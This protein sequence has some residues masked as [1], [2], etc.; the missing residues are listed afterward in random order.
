MTSF[1]LFLLSSFSAAIFS[2]IIISGNTFS[3]ILGSYL[4]LISNLSQGIC[5]LAA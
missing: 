2:S 1:L 4:A 3:K 5:S